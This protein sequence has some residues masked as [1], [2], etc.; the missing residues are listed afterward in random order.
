MNTVFYIS[1]IA[2]A[3]T[4]FIV[5]IAAA[6]AVTIAIVAVTVTVASLP[7]LLQ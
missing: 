1:A 3:V 7:S 6:V 5:A 4:A 2:N